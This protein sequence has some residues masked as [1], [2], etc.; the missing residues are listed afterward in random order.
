MSYNLTGATVSSTYGRIVQVVHGTPDLYYDGFGNLLELGAGTASIGPAG[1]SGT[2]GT[3]GLT[4][5][6][7]TSGLTGTSGTSGLTGTNG[8]SGLTGTSGTSGLTGTNGTSGTSF[9]SLSYKYVTSTYSIVNTDYFIEANGT[10]DVTLPTSVGITGSSFVI[11]NSG[12]GVITIQTTSSQLIDNL[13]SYNLA[14]YDTLL[15]ESNGSNWLVGQPQ[16]KQFIRVYNDTGSIIPK[17]SALKI[18]STYLGIPS[19]TLPI[20]SGSGNQQVIG[21][22][23]IDI[24]IGGEGIAVNSGILSGLNLSA[25]NVGD[26]L[27]LSDTIAGGYVSTTT[28]LQFSSRTNQI[29]YITSN[30]STLGTIQVE[31]N[32]EDIN[33]TLTDIERNIL[34]GNVI[35]TG[36]Y[37]FTPGLTKIGS[38]SFSVSEASGWIVQNTGIYATLPDVTNVIFAGATGLSSP[39][40][41]SADSTYIMLTKYGSLT[42]SASFPSPQQRRENIFLGKVVHPDR[43]TILNVNQTVDYDVS[44]LASLRDLWTPIKGI[45]QGIIVSPHG[46]TLE[47]N[48]SA[49]TLWGNGIGWTTNELNPNSIS[50]LAQDPVTFQYRTRNGGTFSNR[51]TL[52]P[53]NYDNNGTISSVGGGNGSST[54]QR[55]YLFPTGLIRIQYGQKVYGSL[56]EAVSSHQTEQFIE[57]SNNRDNG[58][59]IGIISINK[60]ASNL[61]DP[62]QAVFNYVSKFGE[63]I[64]GSGGLSTTT[65]QQAYNNSVVNPEILTDA[66]GGEFAIRRGSSSDTDNVLVV[67]NGAGDDK[68]YVKGDGN[69]WASSLH[70]TG[71]GLTSGSSK[72]MVINDSGDVFYQTTIV[73]GGGAT[74]PAGPTGAGGALGYYGAFYDNLNQLNPTA[75]TPRAILVGSTYESNGV[76]I[77]EGSKMKFDYPGT[78]NIQFSTVFTKSNSNSGVADIWFVKNGQ[79]VTASNTAFSIAG[80]SDQIASWNFVMSLNSNDYIQLYWSSNDTNISILATDAQSNPDRPSVPSVILTAQQV[81]YTQVGATGSSGTSGT[82]GINGTSGTSGINGTSGSSGTSGTSGS[83]IIILNNTDNFLVTTTGTA[84][85]INGESTLTYDGSTLKLNYQSGDEGGELFLN[86]SVTNTSINTGVTIDVYQN[87]LRFFESGGSGRGA[88]IDLTTQANSVSTNLSPNAYLYVTRNTNQTIGSGNWANQDIIFNNSLL[89]NNITYNTSTG[90]VTLTRGVYRVTARIA[91]S[92]ASPYLIQYACYDSSNTQLS[93]TV[94]QIQPTSGSNNVSSGDLDF[95]LYTPTYTGGNMDIKIRTTSSTTALSGEYI[96]GDLN[97]Q[98]IIQQIG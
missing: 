2:S 14:F 50:I 90:I 53:A 28:S 25:Y 52:D 82:S 83:S 91:W 20:A 74:G 67:Q 22:A 45:N 96:R 70:L 42:Y 62:T 77:V 92:A 21:L 85:Q 61:S 26:I 24:P 89:T 84:N 6:S 32:N 78:Y 88:Y 56:T 9:S 19:V 44:P 79:Y 49:G 17:G 16:T 87:R 51:T 15:V 37:H 43:Q 64:G 30:S 60:N 66:I 71:I 46:T 80:Q 76:S 72:Y 94:E 36:V 97:T 47:I 4:G 39:Y 38:A 34:E 5:T 57:Y 54:N 65:L 10:F 41:T 18:Q 35:S 95:I 75:S 55:V 40:L 93:Q 98:L 68:F 11:K 29:G 3:S 7:G 12:T 63:I 59:L 31:I 73:G 1:T 48:T 58:I 86:K 23:Y 8:T 13:P 81:M 33:L 27:Y 69:T